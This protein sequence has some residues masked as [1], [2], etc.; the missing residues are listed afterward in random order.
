MFF[1]SKTLDHLTGME[2]Q[3]KKW[4][5]TENI[6]LKPSIKIRTSKSEFHDT[7]I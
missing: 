3:N 5:W 6:V 7:V 4:Q 2:Y 1:F